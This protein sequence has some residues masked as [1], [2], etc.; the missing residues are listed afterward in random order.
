MLMCTACT[1]TFPF[2]RPSM[3]SCAASCIGPGSIVQTMQPTTTNGND[4]VLQPSRSVQLIVPTS[5]TTGRGSCQRTRS[6]K[7]ATC[8][9]TAPCGLAP[10]SWFLTHRHF[11]GQKGCSASDWQPQLFAVLVWF[12]RNRVQILQQGLNFFEGKAFRSLRATLANLQIAASPLGETSV[13]RVKF[14]PTGRVES[15]PE[16]AS[17]R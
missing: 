5:N 14:G 13:Q 15:T 9:A 10:F 8:W 12:Q 3:Q 2:T 11:A 6:R 4:Y 7:S 16:N 17:V 1:Y